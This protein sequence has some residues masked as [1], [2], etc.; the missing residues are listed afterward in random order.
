M[1]RVVY[2][3]VWGLAILIAAVLTGCATG[4]QPYSITGG[5]KDQQVGPNRYYV[6]FFGNGNTTR[7]TVFAYWLYRCA[8]LTQEKGFDYFIVVSDAPP[9]GISGDLGG[10]AMVQVASYTITTWSGRG[11][12]EVH[13]G[14]PP[15]HLDHVGIAKDIIAALG[16]AVR[17]AMAS[18]GNVKLPPGYS[19]DPPRRSGPLKLDDLEALLPK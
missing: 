17:E 8:E 12:I 11:V 13:K 2:R 1:R 19:P 18:H 5:Y 15:E 10:S 16:P 4:Y 14:V 3:S 9:P 7:D 6:E